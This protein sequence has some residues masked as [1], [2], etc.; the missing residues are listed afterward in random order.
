MSGTGDLAVLR[1]AGLRKEFGRGAAL[2]RA[3]DIVDLEVA[4]G[5][6]LAVMGPSGCGKS[7]LLHVLLG[8]ERPSAGRVRVG[9]TD[10]GELDLA[11]WHAGLAWVPQRPHLFAGTIADNVRVGRAD[12]TDAA[13]W[14]ALADARLAET[15]AR[16]PHGIGTL[17]G[18][19]GAGLS[20]GER[21]RV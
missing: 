9:G 17:L 8:L 16:L 10:L 2:V 11:A 21:Q 14:R 12:A 13:V 15:V 7:T 4:R 20:A 5:E 18:E 6:T 19:R 3:V 1:A